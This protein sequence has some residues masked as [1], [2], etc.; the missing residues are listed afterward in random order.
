MVG[1][2]ILLFVLKSRVCLARGR[3]RRAAV[4]TTEAAHSFASFALVIRLALSEF[5]TCRRLAH[6]ASRRS[7][8]EVSSSREQQQ[9]AISARISS[10]P[11]FFRSMHC[12]ALQQPRTHATLIH[13]VSQG[14]E[15]CKWSCGAVGRRCSELGAQRC[16]FAHSSRLRSFRLLLLFAFS[17]LFVTSS[18]VWLSCRSLSAPRFCWRRRCIQPVAPLTPLIPLTRATLRP[19]PSTHSPHSTP[20]NNSRSHC[21]PPITRSQRLRAARTVEEA[22]SQ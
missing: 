3:A 4:R 13:A 10:S 18:P 6:S 21:R 9:Q 22:H 11:L 16:L 20:S 8:A 15:A 1:S 7:D 17:R 2:C 5:V 19:S 14:E 12:I